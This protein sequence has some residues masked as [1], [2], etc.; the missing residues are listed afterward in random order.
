MKAKTLLVAAVMFLGLAAAAYAQ[1]TYTVSS[2]PVT[3]VTKTG[4]TE[5]AGEITFTPVQGSPTAVA[6]TIQVTFGGVA[7]TNAGAAIINPLNRNPYTAATGP[8]VQAIDNVHGVVTI[9]VPLL[10]PAF[11]GSFTLTGVRVQ[12]SGTPLTSLSAQISAVN[13]FIVAGQ[14]NPTVITSVGD[15]LVLGTSTAGVVN[16]LT[17]D[18]TT[19]PIIKVKEGYLN[20]FGVAQN[21]LAAAPNDQSNGL[22]IRFT[23]NQ[24]PPSGYTIKFPATAVTDATTPAV[25]QT[26]TVTEATDGSTATVTALNAEVDVTSAAASP[27]KIYYQ[28]VSD[29][30]PTKLETLTIPVTLVYD[31]VTLPVPSTTITWTATL[32]PIGIGLTSA[33]AI[34]SPA[35]VP[36]YA[37]SEIGPGTLI[38]A[39]VGQNKTDILIPYAARLVVSGW[40][41]GIAVSN[42]TK[43]PGTTALGVTGAVAQ[44]GGIHFY[45]YNTG[46]ASSPL[47]YDTQAG[48]PGLGLDA[49]GKLP[50]GSTYSVNLSELIKAASGSD[51]DFNGYIFVITDF[52]L[53]HAQY[54]LTDYVTIANGGQGMIIAGAR[55]SPEGLNH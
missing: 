4:M 22:I 37:D 27:L 18:T 13:N 35:F 47:T 53:G 11:G 25:F 21:G 39:P 23:L 15:G 17:G 10:A 31:K 29:S 3:T 42:T 46:A 9:I 50:P 38:G 7:I 45:M 6:G 49:N 30:D 1:A 40:D 19:N 14:T 20:A 5:K 8:T 44:T 26:A 55:T 51:Q 33:G 34:P 32:C 12:I 43:D 16:L 36:R 52:G 41:T 2:T 48:S 54:L 24:L 28:L